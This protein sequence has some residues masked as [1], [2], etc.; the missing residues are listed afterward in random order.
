VTTVAVRRTSA[1]ALAVE[2]HP[3]PQNALSATL[4]T[5][6]GALVWHAKAEARRAARAFHDAVAAAD[7]RP[8]DEPNGQGHGDPITH[9]VDDSEAE[10]VTASIGR[11]ARKGLLWSLMGAMSTRLGGLLLGMILARLLTPAD[12]GLYAIALSA[13]YFVMHVNDVG[14]IA[15]TV[16]WRGRLEEMA[17][18]ATTLALAFSV[19]IYGLFWVLAPEFTSLAGSSEATPVV[20]LLTMVILVDGVTAVRAGSLVR[21]FQQHR[22][23]IA[24]FLG[25]LVNAAV[26]IS[27]AVH[28]VGALS[29]AAGQVAGAVVIGVFV[30]WSTHM[31]WRFG[32]D[33]AIARRLMQFG[34]PL[35]LALGV[36]SVLL[37]V[38]FILVGRLVGATALGFY[39]LAF[40]ISGWAPAVLGTAIRWVSIPS[41]S[42]LSEEDGALAPAVHRSIASLV[43]AVLPIGFLTAVLAATLI[44]FLYGTGWAPS[45]PALRFLIVLG[46]VRM[47]TQLVL[48]ILAGAGATRAALWLN[49]GW[50][51]ALVPALVIGTQTDGIRG[52][53]VAHALV[54]TF[55]AL[56]LAL[57]ALSRLGVPLV[58][59]A[60]GLVRP[61]LGA[62]VGAVSCAVVAHVTPESD[63]FQLVLAG[64]AGLLTYAV[65]VFPSEQRRRWIGYAIG[66]IPARA[67]PSSA[68]QLRRPAQLELPVGPQ[69]RVTHADRHVPRAHSEPRSERLTPTVADVES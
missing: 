26:A 25:L 18:T 61:L 58:P 8:P 68:K 30:L 22:I 24:N 46:V 60:R 13:M 7:T 67:R 36:E 69:G 3:A 50:V 62:A 29:F 53:A 21:T 40:N 11:A 66:V 16:Q 43:T 41:F 33:R 45:A 2:D 39:L 10:P 5:D 48:D 34:L 14:L 63:L 1:E 28:G 59:I 57:A 15:A 32:F 47:V 51:I 6:R 52:T 42:R 54:A 56:P 44:E 55:V 4:A 9:T 23:T 20:R 27:L 19:V 17:P 49:L 31:P 12:F 35:A 37:N 65:I 64:G 38:D